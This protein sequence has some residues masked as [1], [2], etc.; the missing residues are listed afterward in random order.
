MNHNKSSLLAVLLCSCLLLS[1]CTAQMPV[2][3]TEPTLTLPPVEQL[4]AAPIGDAALEYAATATL[5]LPRYDSNLLGALQAE[6]TFSE[7]RPDAESL[8]RALLNQPETG[9]LSS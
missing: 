4:Y 2:S 9:T 5:Y 6:V 8:V 7:A 3:A 1:G